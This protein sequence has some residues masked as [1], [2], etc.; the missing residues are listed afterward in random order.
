MKFVR[1]E[2]TDYT[3]Q[4]EVS[5]ESKYLRRYWGVIHPP[6]PHGGKKK[7]ILQWTKFLKYGIWLID[8]IFKHC[9]VSSCEF[10]RNRKQLKRSDVVVFHPRNMHEDRL[11]SR[12]WPHQRWLLFNL[13]PPYFTGIQPQRYNNLFNWTM[14]YREDSDFVYSYNQ[15][16]RHRDNSSFT[17]VKIERKSKLAIAMISNCFATN[18]RLEYIQELRKH[19]PLDF[20]GRCAGRVCSPGACNDTAM[21]KYKFYLAFENGNCVSYITEKFWNPLLLFEAVPV[22]LGGSSPRD[23]ELVAPP[24]SYINTADF[25]SPKELAAYLL[26]LDKNDQLYM[27]YHKWRKNYRITSTC[28]PLEL[29]SQVRE[30]GESQNFGTRKSL[31]RPL[32]Q[33]MVPKFS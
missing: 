20:Y 16:E 18:N 7:L 13:E 2:T 30:T 5:Q 24:G 4:N 6:P 14:T 31:M 9:P 19:I 23:Y 12:K 28:T 26:K 33:I 21:K 3:R 22:V 17:D 29:D 8:D 11:P 15:V 27:E 1:T 32:S 10:T 25:S